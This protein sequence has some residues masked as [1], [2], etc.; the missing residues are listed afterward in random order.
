[1]LRDAACLPFFTLCSEQAPLCP[2]AGF[3]LC[4]SK[5]LFSPMPFPVCAGAGDGNAVAQNGRRC[6]MRMVYKPKFTGNIGRTMNGVRRKYYVCNG[7]L[8]V[9]PL[10]NVRPTIVEH[11][12]HVCGTC[13]PHTWDEKLSLIPKIV[14]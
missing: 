9:P 8:I 14:C 12:S 3:V 10:W 13:V 2:D 11:A 7:T 6:G 5:F 4:R 1:M